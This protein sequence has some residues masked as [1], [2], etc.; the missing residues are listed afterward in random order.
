MNCNSSSRCGSVRCANC[1]WR[2]ARFLVHRFSGR[3]GTLH[4]IKLNEAVSNRSS[5]ELFRIS[6][7]NF[8]SYKRAIDPLW[9]RVC[10]VIWRGATDFRGLALLDGVLVQD[11]T[12]QLGRRWQLDICQIDSNNLRREIFFSSE[13]RRL[14]PQWGRG[15]SS[16]RIAS[17]ASNVA[18]LSKP[19]PPVLF[20]EIEPMPMI[21]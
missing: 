20:D 7:R 15:Y 1:A 13:P 4:T 12:A 9:R 17:F 14:G 19:L 18:R 6:F 8:L 2:S 10:I 21:V 16:H 5:Y 3:T 11:F